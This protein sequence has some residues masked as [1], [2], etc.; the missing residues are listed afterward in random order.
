[1]IEV[2]QMEEAAKVQSCLL[3]GSGN[4]AIVTF[5]RHSWIMTAV[6]FQ[7]TNNLIWKANMTELTVN[8]FLHIKHHIMKAVTHQEYFTKHLLAWC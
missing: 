5:N 8:I 3:F 1:M 6:T 4:R 2:E 7:T